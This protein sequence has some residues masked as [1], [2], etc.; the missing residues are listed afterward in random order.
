MVVDDGLIP[1][2]NLTAPDEVLTPFRAKVQ[3]K[4][5]SDNKVVQARLR[6]LFHNVDFWQERA[7]AFEASVVEG[8]AQ[9]KLYTITMHRGVQRW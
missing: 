5:C 8:N 1:I 7:A 3:G 6:T 9:G 4:Y 2:Q